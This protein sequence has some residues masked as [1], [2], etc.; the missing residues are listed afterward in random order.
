VRTSAARVRLGERGSAAYRSFVRGSSDRRLELTIGSRAGLRMLM[1]QVAAQVPGFALRFA[2][3]LQCDLVRGDGRLS[4]WTIDTRSGRALARSGPAD[5]PALT[6]RLSV[7][8]F[9]RMTAGELDPGN[10][11]LDG[12]LDLKGDFSIV[13]LLGLL[14]G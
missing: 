3:E 7:A 1:A 11:L 13:R 12:R 2:G 10:A 4:T 6:A 8:D 14:G 5:A 9:V